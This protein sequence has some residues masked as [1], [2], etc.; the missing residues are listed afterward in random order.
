M[1]HIFMIA[2]TC[3]CGLVV[4]AQQLPQLGKDPVKE[5]VAAMT[6]EEKI[7]MVV[8]GGM[9][10]LDFDDDGNVVPRPIIGNTD[11]M[12]PGAAGTT[13][14]IP[15]LGVLPTVMADGP[16]GLRISPTREGDSNTYYCT[17]FPVATCVASAWNENLAEEVGKAMGNETK[18]YGVDVILAPAMNIQ[19]NPLC[20]RNFEYYS[21]DPL[22]A[23]KMAAAVVRGIQ[24]NGVGVSV[25]HFAANNQETKRY[26]TDSRVSERALREIYLKGF[27][28]VVDEAQPWTIMTSYNRLNGT[29]TSQDKHLLTTILRDE[30][31]F[32]GLVVTDWNSGDS[33][34]KQIEAGNDLLMPG[35]KKQKAVLLEAAK[36]GELD[37]AA[38]D[39]SVERILEYTLKTLSFKGYKCSNKPDLAGHALI[40]RQAAAEGAV[41][42]KNEGQTLPFSKKIKKVALFGNTSFD[43]IAGGSGSGDVN[44][45]YTVSLVEGMKNAGYEL[46]ANLQSRYDA[47]LKVEKEK[48]L[49]RRSRSEEF[50]NKL[51]QIDEMIPEMDDLNRLAKQTDIALIT[52][53]RSSGEGFDRNIK[54]FN[55]NES[56]RQLLERVCK[57]FHD[58][59]KR[60]VV[61]LN[62]GGVIETASWRDLPD[63]ILLPWQAGQEG[64]NT[65]ADIL[66]GKVTPSGKLPMSFPLAYEDVPS[67]MNFPYDYQ[68]D[69]KYLFPNYEDMG[70]TNIKNEDYTCY[71]EGI[72][73]G[74]RYYDT[75]NK[76]VSYPF[77]FGLSYTSFEYA[78][79]Q[80]EIS[81]N[82]LITVKMDVTNAGQ[83]AGKEVVQLYVSAPK[84][85]IDKPVKELRDFAKTSLLQPGQKETV[86]MSFTPADLASFYEKEKAWITEAGD[87][88]IL[89]GASATDIRQRSTI[90]LPN[91]MLIEQVM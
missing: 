6:L 91:R 40:T 64:G 26:F 70:K 38:L 13:N 46:D 4:Q 68:L 24:S 76:E 43:F 3:F 62:I 66:V 72:Y 59:K 75:Q 50:F 14:A 69:E 65:V 23:G 28:M 71:E 61:V 49:K 55:L 79:P 19:R 86:T 31:G 47:Y 82:G 29:F 15:R 18:E 45:A 41:L 1:K 83:Y 2:A 57:A 25:K 63:A 56:E 34:A 16:A 77:G 90:N 9:P 81:D 52:I 11:K 27:R 33:P 54:D 32:Q 20:G 35:F 60:V 87:Y 58:A 67:A 12:V 7:S 5:I 78:T 84:V 53:G 17:G 88:Q 48:A 80:V 89:L 74:Y 21:E 42:L 39:R 8:G 22:L 30:W 36:N 73:V 85:G 44:K 10:G 37:L 51:P